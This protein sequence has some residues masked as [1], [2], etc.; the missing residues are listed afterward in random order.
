MRDCGGRRVVK[1]LVGVAAVTT[2]PARVVAAVM[3]LPARVVA[4][5]V[6]AGTPVAL[7]EVPETGAP[8]TPAP[9]VAELVA[10]GTPVALA[11]EVPGTGAPVIPALVVPIVAPPVTAGDDGLVPVVVAALIPVAAGDRVVPADVAAP[12]LVALAPVGADVGAEAVA[13]DVV[14]VADELVTAVAGADPVVIADAT[15]VAEPDVVA[16]AVGSGGAVGGLV[17][18]VVRR[19]MQR[20][21]QRT[22]IILIVRFTLTSAMMVKMNSITKMATWGNSF[23]I[24]DT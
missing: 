19:R 18:T 2:V 21:G 20:T 13:L 22:M 11:V 6:A 7:V 3:T 24:F 15:A 16:I 12:E 4:A 14:M 5:L 23:I 9:V 17:V 10:A 8:V 1:D